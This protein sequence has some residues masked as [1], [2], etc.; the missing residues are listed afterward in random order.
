[1]VVDPFIVGTDGSQVFHLV[2]S[3]L[4]H[5]LYR[6]LVVCESIA[7]A[8]IR[9]VRLL[10]NIAIDE[11]PLVLAPQFTA[12][13]VL[14][15]IRRYDNLQLGRVASGKDV[16]AAKNEVFGTQAALT[17][18]TSLEKQFELYERRTSSEGRVGN[19]ELHRHV[20]IGSSGIVLGKAHGA[21][22]GVPTESILLDGHCAVVIYPTDVAVDSDVAHVGVCGLIHID[23]IY[24][25]LVG[26]IDQRVL[27]AHSSHVRLD[28]V[29]QTALKLLVVHITAHRLI[30][31]YR[32]AWHRQERSR[33]QGGIQ[34]LLD[35]GVIIGA[36]V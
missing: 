11:E 5:L 23:M 18:L 9:V 30:G 35:D 26:H 20:G 21:Q 25:F 36:Q 27:I 16:G 3:H 24:E 17:A 4:R 2:S 22:A 33:R 12:E 28:I 10:L 19:G 29:S 31:T 32:Q 15:A 8:V 6:V 13:E 34:R 7:H 14:L 1:M